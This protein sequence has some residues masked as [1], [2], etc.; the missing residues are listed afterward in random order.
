MQPRPRT[1]PTGL[2]GAGRRSPA[3][4]RGGAE[5]GAGD[6]DGGADGG[7]ERPWNPHRTRA[8]PTRPTG[9]KRSRSARRIAT[10]SSSR[11]LETDPDGR[12]V[13]VQEEPER[14]LAVFKGGAAAA[15]PIDHSS[16]SFGARQRR[17]RR[18]SARDARAAARG[19]VARRVARLAQGRRAHAG[20]R[21][22]G[23][24]ADTFPG[25]D[26]AE[27]AAAAGARGGGYG[28]ATAAGACR[29]RCPSSRAR[30][31]A[32][33]ARQRHH[34]D[35][36]RLPRDFES[37]ALPRPRSRATPPAA[38]PGGNGADKALLA[39]RALLPAPTTISVEQL[40]AMLRAY[41]DVIEQQR[42]RRRL[43]GEEEAPEPYVRRAT[44]FAL[45]GAWERSRDDALAALA[46]RPSMAVAN[47]RVGCAHLMLRDYD[48]AT[49]AFATGL[50]LAPNNVDLANAHTLAVN[51][52]AVERKRADGALSSFGIL[53]RIR[54]ENVRRAA[55]AKA[56]ALGVPDG[57]QH[58][59]HLT[60]SATFKSGGSGGGAPPRPGRRSQKTMN[61]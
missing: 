53:H 18:G 38:R 3:R 2:G 31:R 1:T 34:G 54:E 23:A 7:A 27:H 45:M 21:T 32:H 59:H 12:G 17:R 58:D 33:G 47:Y 10:P 57:H 19:R 25:D 56:K 14:D 13:P 60:H 15:A 50:R 35:P 20:S 52:L 61:W 6:G 55:E 4:T 28:T 26:A 39:E 41:T 49:S 16:L 8:C 37:V 43:G 51:A 5:G 29:S 46:L 36:P 30:A 24:R 48:A 40:L 11:S 42:R 9:S 22:P 44:L